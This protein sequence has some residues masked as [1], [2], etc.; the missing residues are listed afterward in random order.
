MSEVSAEAEAA[1]KRSSRNLETLRPRLESWLAKQLPSG[2]VPRIARVESPKGSGMS[3]ETLLFDASWT[4]AGAL[5]RGA[6]VARLAPD[7]ADLPVFPAYDLAQQFRLLRLLRERSRVPVPVAR[8]LE[9]DASV[10]GAPFFVMERVPGRVPPDV[11]PYTMGGWLAD[12]TPA[13]QRALQEATVEVIAELHRVDARDARFLEFELPGATPLRRHF[14]NQ[15]RFYAWVRGERRFPLLERSFEWLEARW[16]MEAAPAVISWG[17]SRIGN[18]IYEPTGWR[19][20]AVLDWE[21]AALGP[22]ELDLGWLCFL[23][24]FFDDLTRRGGLPG[25]PKFLR[26][27]DVAAHY[28]KL[29]GHRPRDLAWYECYAALRHG[30]I[31]ARI[32]SRMVHFGAAQFPA[33]PDDAVP[34]RPALEA[35]LDGCYWKR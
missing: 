22:R 31:M 29:S 4:E 9:E 19:P 33:D 35:M 1:A 12:A 32:T 15:R 7:P 3:S 6:F 13:E 26:A 20:V 5:H 18:V 10:L 2:S 14:E 16:P 17:D 8:W 23:H 27:D 28:E 24:A 21:M 34:H 30:I 25:M 11:M